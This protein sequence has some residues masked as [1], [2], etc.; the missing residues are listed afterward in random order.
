MNSPSTVFVSMSRVFC[1]LL[2]FKVKK[3]DFVCIFIDRRGPRFE[4]TFTMYCKYQ[5]EKQLP[6]RIYDRA[7]LIF[8]TNRAPST[9]AHVRMGPG[10]RL[11][12]SVGNC[13]CVC[14]LTGGMFYVLNIR[15]QSL[16]FINRCLGKFLEVILKWFHFETKQCF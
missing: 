3:V 6:S 9:C 5:I 13:V 7:R 14:I 4:H 12:T 16:R 2:I 10:V 8:G 15:Y 11:R 1:H